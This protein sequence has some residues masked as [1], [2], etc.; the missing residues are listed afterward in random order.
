MERNLSILSK[1]S[2]VLAEK[3]RAVWI[4]V[5]SNYSLGPGEMQHRQELL[6]REKRGRAVSEC[7]Q[8][9]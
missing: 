4:L 5:N 8:V 3:I 9:R 1:S 6:R 2:W 7:D